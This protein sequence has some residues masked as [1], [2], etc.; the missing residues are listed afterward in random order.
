MSDDRGSATVWAVGVIAALLV[1]GTAGIDLASAVRAR[2]IAEAAA[3]LAALA[4]A[5][6]SSEGAEGACAIARTGAERNGA[7][8]R[9]CRLDGWDA[10]VLVEVSRGWTLVGRGP[11]GA[12][13]RAGPAPVDTAQ[14]P[15]VPERPTS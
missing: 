8:L 12:A 10:V 5:G 2:H 4:A 15:D 9:D 11:A 6:R 14:A 3:D 13:A 1:L 7:V